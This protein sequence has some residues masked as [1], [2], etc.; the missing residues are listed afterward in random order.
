MK[1]IATIIMI[2]FHLAGLT[3]KAQKKN[4]DIIRKQQYCSAQI[5]MMDKSVEK[6]ALGGFIGDSIIVYEL[7]NVNGHLQILLDRERRIPASELKRVKIAVE[8]I[9]KSPEIFTK[10]TGL[11]KHANTMLASNIQGTHAIDGVGKAM[12]FSAQEPITLFAGIILLPVIIPVAILTAKEKTY[13]ING[14]AKRL[15]RMERK[16]SR[17]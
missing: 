16:L 9:R 4:H 5:T 8:K 2:I 17:K 13:H 6:F 11:Q 10:S 3:S 12:A 1:K 14:N 7:T 15:E